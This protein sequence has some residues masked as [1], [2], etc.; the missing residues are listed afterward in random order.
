MWFM[1]V[2]Q[3][4]VAVIQKR[5]RNLLIR[6]QLDRWKKSEDDNARLMKQMQEEHD[7]SQRPKTADPSK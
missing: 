1:Y 6:T 4:W 2:L 3:K 7:K 5:K